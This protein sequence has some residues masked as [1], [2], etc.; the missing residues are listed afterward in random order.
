MSGNY[1]IAIA[2]ATGILGG[3]IARAVLQPPYDQIFR[4]V[5]ILTRDVS[6]PKAQALKA[7]GGAVELTEFNPVDELS[8]NNALGGV[9]IFI[10]SLGRTTD[11][12][13]KIILG[14]LVKNKVKVYIPSEYGNDHSKNDFE[15]AVSTSKLGQ[16][17]IARKMGNGLLKVV[18][19]YTGLFPETG[20]INSGIGP[21]LG[22]DQENLTYTTVGDP[23]T[24]VTYTS[25]DDIAKSV[26]RLS[27]LAIEP[28]T[29]DSVPD[30]VTLSGAA[31]SYKDIAG[32]VEK[33]TD[34]RITLKSL[35]INAWR[36]KMLKEPTLINVIRYLIGSG[37]MNYEDDNHNELVNPG[38]S[39]WKWKTVEEVIIEQ[40]VSG[41]F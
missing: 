34:E 41:E 28:S 30:H 7:L 32:F 26:A 35:D 12:V 19:V 14:G 21:L 1:T 9:D 3:L 18:A 4:Q 16:Q 8:V 38:Q 39:V 22:F 29:A 13:H 36:E 17:D 23:A 5:R 10:S 40:H 24:R 37:K 2:G 11:E 25:V 6:S 27:H 15:V 31:V 33:A 20:L